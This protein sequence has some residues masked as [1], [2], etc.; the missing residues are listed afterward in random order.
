[1]AQKIVSL[2]G[3]GEVVLAKRK[4]TRNLRLSIGADGRIRVGLPYW[5]PYQA[6]ISF[7]LSRA[8]WIK[9]HAPEPANGLLAEGMRVGKSYRLHFIRDDSA[10]NVRSRLVAN[11]IIIKGPVDPSH[12]ATQKVAAAACERALKKDAEK[13]LP[14]RVEA[15]ART[16]GFNYKSV[17]V[18]RLR[19]RWGSC[20]NQKDITLN[21]YLIQL[22]WSLIDYVILHELTHTKH[23][24]HGSAFWEHLQALS[25]EVKRHRQ[26]IKRHKPVLKPQA[27][28]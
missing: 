13:L 8:E 20:S 18:K 24:H 21:Y 16:G 3:I 5:A 6:G 7:A 23:L 17:R 9:R 25:P 14:Q 27:L 26:D 12:P 2:P 22:P 19:S 15:L 1:M 10:K 4:G 28:A 11:Q